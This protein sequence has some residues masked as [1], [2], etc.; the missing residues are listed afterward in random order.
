MKL[1]LKKILLLSSAVL[2]IGISIS[3]ET[4]LAKEITENVHYEQSLVIQ[5]TDVSDKEHRY[6]ASAEVTAQNT[7]SQPRPSWYIS[8]DAIDIEK[9][10]SAGRFCYSQ[11]TAE[12]KH[13]YEKIRKAIEQHR[14]VLYWNDKCCTPSAIDTILMC[15]TYDYPEYFWYSD[16]Y[17]YAVASVD[18]NEVAEKI[19]LKYEYDKE[20]V[21]DMTEKIYYVVNEYLN[22]IS[23]LKSDYD[24][25]LAGYEYI[26]NNTRYDSIRAEYG[27][28]SFGEMDKETMSCWNISGVFLHHNAICRGYVQAYQY[29]MNLQGIKCGYVYGDNH[30]WNVIQLDGDW[31]YTDITW[32]DPVLKLTHQNEGYVE[33]IQQ[34]I[35]YSYFCMTTQ[36]LLQLHTP[37][38]DFNLELP[39]CTATK[40]N[41]FTRNPNSDKHNFFA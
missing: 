19:I 39:V 11:M 31:Y 18:N 3:R 27:Y 10:P 1:I 28:G 22:S 29:L 33:Y 37:D 35:D 21:Y 9:T 41:Y 36:Q 13:C 25:A 34:G 40:D 17:C 15:I 20:E 24:K 16:E 5:P 6:N 7:V 14:T 38:F 30:C 23:H 8:D 32:G 12:Q 26:I 4:N 2:I